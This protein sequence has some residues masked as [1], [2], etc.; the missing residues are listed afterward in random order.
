VEEAVLEKLNQSLRRTRSEEA[1]RAWTVL[2]LFVGGLAALVAGVFAGQAG[3]VVGLG[4]AGIASVLLFVLG[5]GMIVLS[6]FLANNNIGREIGIEVA[7]NLEGAGADRFATV[8]EAC[9]AL[10]GASGQLQWVWGDPKAPAAKRGSGWGTAKVVKPAHLLLNVR[11]YGLGPIYFLPDTV[12]LYRRN[13]QYTT[14]SLQGL[15][16]EPVREYEDHPEGYVG[17]RLRFRDGECLEIHS[18]ASDVEWLACFAN[19]MSSIATGDGGGRSVSSPGDQETRSGAGEQSS[20]WACSVLGVREDAPWEVVEA[21]YRTLARQYH[22][23]KVAGLGGDLR[24]VA[25]AKMKDINQAFELLG[26][27]A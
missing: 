23:D 17:V 9:R 15:G 7:Y 12:L 27:R 21:A 4:A 14:H 18:A 16:V 3:P 11:T 19:G 2:W 24:K 10:S 20:A 25:E 13:G 6:L 22:P 26:R 8:T 1:R 5:G